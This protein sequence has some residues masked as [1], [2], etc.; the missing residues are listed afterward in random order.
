LSNYH[1]RRKERDAV[2]GS[3]EEEAA[4]LLINDKAFAE[5]SSKLETGNTNLF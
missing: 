5:P 2:F 3:D 4:E 1:E